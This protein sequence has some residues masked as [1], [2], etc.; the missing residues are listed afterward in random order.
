MKIGDKVIH[1]GRVFVLRGLDPMS[2]PEGRA[3]VEDPATGEHKLVPIAE[4]RPS[5][6]GGGVSA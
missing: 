5:G 2:V 3:E 1:D 4:I 6:P